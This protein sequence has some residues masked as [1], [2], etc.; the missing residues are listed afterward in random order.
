MF[1]E[2]PDIMTPA[3]VAE[4]LG[5]GRNSVYSLLRSGAIGHKRIG[6]KYIIPKVCLIAYAKSAYYSV[7]T[8]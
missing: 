5:V 8:L 2:Y 7:K 6:K 4:A 1:K 3:Q